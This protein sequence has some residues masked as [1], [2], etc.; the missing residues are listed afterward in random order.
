MP[1]SAWYAPYAAAAV[2]E[3]LVQGTS[4]T[5]FS[6]DARLTRE[7]LAVLVARAL[8]LAGDPLD[9]DRISGWTRAGVSADVTA[10]L[11]EG[12]PD[13]TFGPPGTAT[14]AQAARIL[15]QALL[16]P[17]GV[18]APAVAGGDEG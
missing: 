14:R 9:A 12:F 2:R 8:N 11:I 5:T 10:G 18:A 3:G 15:A 7:Q 13:G 1:P 17:G 6:P 16:R 4:P